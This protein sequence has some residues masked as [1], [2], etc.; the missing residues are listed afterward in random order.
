M[1][2]KKKVNKPFKKTK[3]TVINKLKHKTN[4]T[5]T[6]K[7]N[8]YNQHYLDTHQKNK[9]N[10]RKIRN[11]N[12]EKTDQTGAGFFFDNKK[13]ALGN[14]LEKLK[15]TEKQLIKETDKYTET[16]KKYY[17]ILSDHTINL[18]KFEL[19]LP[20]AR[21]FTKIF[22]D[23]IINDY[24]TTGDKINKANPLFIN[25]YGITEYSSPDEIITEHIRQQLRHIIKYRLGSN[26]ENIIR[27]F[28]IKFEE[29][30]TKDIIINFM[31]ATGNTTSRVFSH[32][33]YQLDFDKAEAE[34]RDVIEATE[35]IAEPPLVAKEDKYLTPLKRFE[36]EK[37]RKQKEIDNMQ[38][39]GFKIDDVL[40]VGVDK[41]E[42]NIAKAP[43]AEEIKD[44]L[45]N[46]K[47]NKNT[48]KASNS[49]N[50]LLAQIRGKL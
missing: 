28:Y 32:T 44:A 47:N 4:K 42:I 18:K 49:F 21:S 13:S 15:Q 34:L 37:E 29:D 45:K 24:I 50:D 30:P 39:Q 7:S 19:M 10:S 6:K 12:N 5:Q 11:I 35:K 2:S 41:A 26:N 46:N 43:N 36:K 25:S 40:R 48:N 8:K 1:K 38:Q 20:F 31:L 3:P 17:S 33:E 14:A 22:N 27:E 16:K 9:Y 23:V